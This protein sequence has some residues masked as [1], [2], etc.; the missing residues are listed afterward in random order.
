MWRDA[1]VETVERVVERQA[2]VAAEAEDVAHAVQLQHADEGLGPGQLVHQDLPRSSG[3]ASAAL[4]Q[5]ANR[6]ADAGGR[7]R[8]NKTVARLFIGQWLGP[9]AIRT[10]QTER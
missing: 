6:I 7:R 10:V 2:G 4:P 9:G 5:G 1:V 3:K 8:R